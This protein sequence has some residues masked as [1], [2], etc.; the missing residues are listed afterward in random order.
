MPYK[1]KGKE[2]WHFKHGKWSIKQVAKSHANAIKT[3]HLL[4]GFEHGW[5]PDRSKNCRVVKNMLGGK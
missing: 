3:V 4:Q 2:V 5:Y 1:I